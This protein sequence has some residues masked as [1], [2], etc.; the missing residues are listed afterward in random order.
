MGACL[1]AAIATAALQPVLGAPPQTKNAGAGSSDIPKTFTAP[2]ADYDYVKRELMIP[3]RDGVRLH[4]VIVIPKGAR[5]APILLT[6]TPYKRLQ[7][8]H[9]QR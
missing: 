6:R 3:M 8:H 7:A 2:L 4:T 1:L 5:N 9:P